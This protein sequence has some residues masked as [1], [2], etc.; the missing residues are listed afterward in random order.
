MSA[1]WYTCG[2]A[3]ID[4]IT[5]GLLKLKNIT[6]L[7]NS[8]ILPVSMILYSIQPLLFFK[9]LSFQGIGIVN[10]LWNAT[11]TGIIALIG[12]LVFKEKLSFLNC[13]GIFLCVIGI[14]LIGFN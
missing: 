4:I 6:F 1:I 3:F 7:D 13:L 10:G 9:A 12:F 11:S 5:M 8:Y 2:M 14:L